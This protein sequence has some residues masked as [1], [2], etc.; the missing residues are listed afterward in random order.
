MSEG[1][2][3]WKRFIKPKS[4]E[5]GLE[6]IKYHSIQDSYWNYFHFS[7]FTPILFK[8]YICEIKSSELINKN[9]NSNEMITIKFERAPEPLF[10]L[11]KSIILVDDCKFSEM[12]RYKEVSLPKGSYLVQIRIMPNYYSNTLLI[13]ELDYGKTIHIEGFFGR[14]K[15]LTI[16]LS[17]WA[18]VLAMWAFLNYDFLL[19]PVLIPSIFILGYYFYFSKYPQKALKIGIKN[20]S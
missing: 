5:S 7:L 3:K 2:V 10:F 19:F 4:N 6:K 9:S 16:L 12:E 17:I 11:K 14:H 1:K 8:P 15:F 18:F 20:P 13:N